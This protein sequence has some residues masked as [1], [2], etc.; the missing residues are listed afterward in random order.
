MY[1]N[2]QDFTFKS[3]LKCQKH[4]CDLSTSSHSW[5]SVLHLYSQG[6]LCLTT[7]SCSNVNYKF[8]LFQAEDKKC[9][10][11]PLS[12]EWEKTPG[13]LTYVTQSTSVFVMSPVSLHSDSQK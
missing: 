2:G 3:I 5:H 10:R 12:S 4:A 11:T 9:I 7:R 1:L 6:S 13:Q 8:D